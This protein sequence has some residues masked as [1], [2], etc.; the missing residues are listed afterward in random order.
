[1]V[2]TQVMG[3]HSTITIANSN[4]HLQ[5]NAYKPVIVYNVLQSIRLLSDA[6]TSLASHCI[7]DM[8]MNSERIQTNLS[9]S[10]MLVTAL[11]PKIGYDK[12]AEVAKLAYKEGITLKQAV[13]KLGYMSEDEADKYLVADKML[14][15]SPK[16]PV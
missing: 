7:E 11:N 9:Q 14:G 6:C 5:L 2:A 13:V 3:N 16:G 1:M 4:G 12:A 8:T 15:N 10:L